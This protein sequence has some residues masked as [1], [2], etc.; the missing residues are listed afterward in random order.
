[1]PDVSNTEFSHQDFTGFSPYY[2]PFLLGIDRT[3]S[4]LRTEV[5]TTNRFY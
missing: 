2:K 4:I 5:R 3:L 1:M